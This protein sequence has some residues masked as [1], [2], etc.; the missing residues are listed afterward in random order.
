MKRKS[1]AIITIHDAPSMTKRGRTAIARWMRR[2]AD[3]LERESKNLSRRF[4]ARYLYLALA[5]I[6]FGLPLLAEAQ[7]VKPEGRNLIRCHTLVSTATT[8]TELTGCAV[9]AG[10]TYYVTDIIF[11]SSVISATAADSQLTLKYGT[12]TACATGT[13]VFW[14]ASNL[15][16]TTVTSH[17]Q[18]PIRIPKG[19]AICWIDSP[20]GTKSVTVLGYKEF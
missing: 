18:T 14:V 12:G 15:A 2:Q 7:S 16:H 6:V 9:E 4:T 13:A 19:N 11:A 1:A 8:L 10:T 5:V 20:A 17:L 3:F